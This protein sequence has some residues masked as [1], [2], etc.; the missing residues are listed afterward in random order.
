M[1]GEVKHVKARNGPMLFLLERRRIRRSPPSGN[2]GSRTFARG[3]A[4]RASR[5]SSVSFDDGALGACI[6]CYREIGR[7]PAS[8]AFCP[9]EVA[10]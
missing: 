9:P 4:V 8:A 3:P 5:Q 6:D 7:L 2:A 10:D 1:N